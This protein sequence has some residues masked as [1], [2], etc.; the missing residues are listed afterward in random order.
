MAVSHVTAAD[1]FFDWVLRKNFLPV[2]AAGHRPIYL[3]DKQALQAV[4]SPEFRP[5]EAV[6][7]P[8]EAGPF[9]SV[10]NR[11]SARVIRS[12]FETQRVEFDIEAAEPSLITLSQ[13]YYHR[14]HA[15]ID[16]R[17]ARLLRANYAFQALEVPGGKHTVRL[18]YR[19][20]AFYAGSVISAMSLLACVIFWLRNRKP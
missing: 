12:R 8:R 10:T 9:V 3:E 7:L 16:G 20:E 11:T 14:W 2:I 1:R 6:I 5:D 17:P 13:T 4:L 18:I 19:D 15:S